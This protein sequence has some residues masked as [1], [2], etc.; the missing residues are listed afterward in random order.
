MYFNK[1]KLYERERKREMA[2]SNRM[3]LRPGILWLTLNLALTIQ[4]INK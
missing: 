2:Y 1:A 4:F 3:S